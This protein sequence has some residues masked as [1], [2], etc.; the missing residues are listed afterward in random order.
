[1][2]TPIKN[3]GDI[4]ERGYI[5]GFTHR[6]FNAP[7]SLLELIANILDSMDKLTSSRSFHRKAIFEVRS[8]LIRLIDNA[9]GMDET[10]IA[11]MFSLHRE[12]HAGDTSRGVS[13]IGGKAA[14]YI[15]SKQTDVTI[16]TRT[17]GGTYYRIFVPWA[18]IKTSGIYTGKVT[19]FEMTAEEREAFVT[20]RRVNEMLDEE[21]AHG[22]TIVFQ[23]NEELTTLITNTF[24]GIEDNELD[25][26]VE[27]SD[28]VFGRENIECICKQDTGTSQ[29]SLYNYFGESNSQYYTGITTH[30]IQQWS[31]KEDDRFVWV[32]REDA[33]FETPKVGKGY[34][35]DVQPL[36]DNLHG[37]TYMGHYTVK[38]GLRLDTTYFDPVDL[39]HTKV[40]GYEVPKDKPRGT[41]ANNTV[42]YPYDK[43]H[44]G[45][46]I[47]AQKYLSKIKLYRNNMLIGPIPTPDISDANARANFE[48]NLELM[49]V[50]AEVS[51]NPVSSQNNPQ[52]RIMGIQ[53]NKG[54]FNGEAVPKNLTRLVKEMRKQKAKEIY[55]Y[56]QDVIRAHNPPA[57]PAPP[58]P[59]PP[60][61]LPSDSDD[62]SDDNSSSDSEISPKPRLPTPTPPLPP[63]PPPS[64]PRPTPLRNNLV[65]VDLA[66]L[67]NAT[68]ERA[69]A[70]LIAIIQKYNLTTQ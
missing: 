31:K 69:H 34:S 62:S 51:Y 10:G 47:A 12:N 65:I 35:K 32:K 16:Y 61:P 54:Q 67:D 66:E 36:G 4:N 40:K 56:F 22:T 18:D 60:T 15:L 53:E 52:D 49:R 20:E 50:Q 58:P 29:L 8:D 70:E 48:A 13:G 7:K 68:Y 21:D 1:M 5:D 46:G 14:L 3:V 39:A 44:L 26:L 64:P 33:K 19:V 23:K 41:P 63:S 17:P 2:S 24:D 25:N 30:V 11:N 6:G 57:P 59:S 43:K 38:V 55:K 9:M 45:S 37:Y 28:I 27:R 42:I